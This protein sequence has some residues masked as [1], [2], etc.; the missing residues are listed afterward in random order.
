MTA[1]RERGRTGWTNWS[2]IQRCDPAQTRHPTT[3]DE[4]VDAVAEATRAGR[5]VKVAGSGHSFTGIA[6]TDGTHIHLDRYDQVLEADRES[7]RVRVQAGIRLRDLN[8][9]LAAHGLAMENLGDI[10][11]QTISGATQTGTHGTGARLGNLSTQIVGLRLVTAGG[12]VIDCNAEHD[13]DVFHAAR[14]GLGA[15]GAVSTVTLRGVPAFNLHALEQSERLDDLLGDLDG[16]A[17]ANEHFE[18]H[19]FPHTPYCQ[20]KRNNRTDD[21]VSTRGRWKEWRDS[22]LMEN[23]LFGAVCRLGRRFPSRIPALARFV[24]SQVGKVWKVER[25]DRVFASTRLVHFNEME[26]AIPR[27]EAAG[28][29]RAV[30][31]LIDRTGI[32]TNIPVEV[33]F[34]AGDDIWL[35]PAHG[36]DTC[37]IAVHQFWGLPFTQY[38][39]G[40]EEIMKARGGRPHWGKLHYQ[41]AE[42]LAPRY[43]RWS[44][45]QAVRR[46][47]DPEGTF[48][49]EYLDRV[50]G[51]I[52]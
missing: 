3:E 38:F 20:T 51:P 46:R 43:Q 24:G 32:R 8:D 52:P 39:L 2:R 30:R 42:T 31:D 13:A 50:L 19:W 35:S 49:N 14:I 15:L 45:F 25:S 44:D 41:S 40:V 34:V 28:A 37:Y 12:D 26:Y 23:V 10:A 36:R 11:E 21:A 47:L 7:G 27:E 18:F 4:L 48:T 16:H 22:I 6:L 9:A 29:I 17:D 5:R 1:H 33:R